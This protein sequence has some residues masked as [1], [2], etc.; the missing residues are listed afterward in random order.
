MQRARGT[1]HEAGEGPKDNAKN[2]KPTPPIKK[3][4]TSSFAANS[5]LPP[6]KSDPVLSH[7]KSSSLSN[8]R[9]KAK[10]RRVGEIISK[11][12]ANRKFGSKCP[13]PLDQGRVGS[14]ARFDP[15][16]KGIMPSQQERP[17]HLDLCLRSTPIAVAKRGREDP[18]FLASAIHP[19]PVES[20]S[21]RLGS[22]WLGS[23]QCGWVFRKTVPPY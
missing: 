2:H 21:V 10:Q 8:T 1:R 6:P 13:L 12:Q 14:K 22:A 15:K 19:S 17:S 11:Q 18:P 16:E 7:L 5:V 20:R 3:G 4:A 23:V 9:R